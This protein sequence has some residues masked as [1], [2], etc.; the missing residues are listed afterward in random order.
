VRV[1]LPEVQRKCNGNDVDGVV[2]LC[3][4]VA[5]IYAA[6]IH[7]FIEEALLLTAQ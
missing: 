6:L 7:S 3:N 2:N 4:T 5:R 1:S